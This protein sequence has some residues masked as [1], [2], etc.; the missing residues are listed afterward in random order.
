DL[1]IGT[2]ARDAATRDALR[3][4]DIRDYFLDPRGAD[5]DALVYE[6]FKPRSQPDAGLLSSSTVIQPGDAAGEFY[7]TRGHYHALRDRSEVYV[8][9]AG[10]GLLVL[11]D[12]DGALR[13]EVM[14][15]G[16]LRFIPG[17][18][19][20]RVVNTGDVPLAFLA[21]YP[22]DAGNDYDAIRVHGFP[23]RVFRGAAGPELRRSAA[24]G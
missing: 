12:A 6:V 15:R 19:A 5:A 22:A 7:M 1:D 8:G 14:R 13:T 11:A 20:H 3:F 18:W 9:L 24:G 23:V 2:M 21:V 16:A 10:E 4:G 17:G